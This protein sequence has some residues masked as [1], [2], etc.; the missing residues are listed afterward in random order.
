M[1][2]HGGG[3]G[4]WAGGRGKGRAAGFHGH[5]AGCRA[6]L[7]RGV[8]SPSGSRTATISADRVALL[9]RQVCACMSAYVWGR[10]AQEWHCGWGIAHRLSSGA[11]RGAGAVW[12]NGVIAIAVLRLPLAVMT[13]VVMML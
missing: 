8:Q 4:V 2:G 11:A 7:P 6:A 5:P 1:D 10:A 12:P 9:A 3:G 13:M